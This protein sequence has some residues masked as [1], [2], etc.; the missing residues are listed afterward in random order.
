MVANPMKFYTFEYRDSEID[1]KVVVFLRDSFHFFLCVDLIYK[2]YRFMGQYYNL[3]TPFV[4]LSLD[5]LFNKY[6]YK[7]VYN[8]FY[9]VNY[10]CFSLKHPT[11]QIALLFSSQVYQYILQPF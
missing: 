11:K 9:F 7:W 3:Y 5:Y 4:K 1:I 8:Y 6:K 10:S 2:S